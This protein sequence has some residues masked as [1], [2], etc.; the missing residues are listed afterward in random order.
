MRV[1]GVTKRKARAVLSWEQALLSLAGLVIGGGVMRVYQG[2][3]IAV[4]A[5][6]L[7]IFATLYLGVIVGAAVTCAVLATRRSPLELLQT[8]E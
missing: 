8:K 1:L 6:R 5:V 3:A 4:I 7:S 2:A